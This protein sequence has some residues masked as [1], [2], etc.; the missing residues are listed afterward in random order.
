MHILNNPVTQVLGIYSRK[1]EGRYIGLSKDVYK[2]VNNGT[3]ELAL[4]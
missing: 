4:N 2:N 3:I 1:K